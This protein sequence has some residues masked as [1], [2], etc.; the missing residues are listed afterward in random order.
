MRDQGFDGDCWAFSS[1]GALEF[2]LAMEAR[3]DYSEIGAYQKDDETAADTP[4][5][6]HMAS[7]LNTSADESAAHETFKLESGGNNNMTEAYLLRGDGPVAVSEFDEAAYDEYNESERADYSALRDAERMDIPYASSVRI[8]ESDDTTG[9]AVPLMD[10]SMTVYYGINWRMNEDV[11]DALKS[12][13]LEYGAVSV[14]Y[15]LTRRLR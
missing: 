14:N 2:Q 13:V 1:L 10:E 6:Y 11:V 4:S 12:A 7:A 9:R 5:E 3:G 8:T 15:I